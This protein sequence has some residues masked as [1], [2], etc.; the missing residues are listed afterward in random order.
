MIH[1]RSSAQL[2]LSHP[3]AYP[4]LF[5]VFSDPSRELLVEHQT[6]KVYARLK[7]TLPEMQNK[8]SQTTIH[9][10]LPASTNTPAW[11]EL[12]TAT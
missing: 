11:T 12:L 9:A 1:L 6:T 5:M 3:S 10:E 7:A 8:C 2:L 4:Y